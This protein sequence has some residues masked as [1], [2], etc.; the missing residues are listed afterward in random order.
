MQ[1]PKITGKQTETGSYACFFM[2]LEELKG[3]NADSSKV[4]SS[5]FCRIRDRC[6]PDHL[7]SLQLCHFGISVFALVQLSIGLFWLILI[8]PRLKRTF[9]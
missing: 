2:R 6:A 1:S 5:C 4:S 9:K 7:T 8:A 3:F